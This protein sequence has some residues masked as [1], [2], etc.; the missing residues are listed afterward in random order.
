[1][2]LDVEIWSGAEAR[3]RKNFKFQRG[4][5]SGGGNR[6][7]RTFAPLSVDGLGNALSER[8]AL[9]EIDA[10]LNIR[11]TRMAGGALRLKRPPP[12]Y[13]FA[14]IFFEYRCTN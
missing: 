3:D 13:G 10:D 11:P 7:L 1:M 6:R 5:V 8:D 12:G 9:S 4:L 2:V 14:V